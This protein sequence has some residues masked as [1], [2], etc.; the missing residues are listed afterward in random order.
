MATVV[1][2]GACSDRSLASPGAPSGLSV[3]VGS[4]ERVRS[5]VASLTVPEKRDLLSLLDD[6]ERRC[7]DFMPRR[8]ITRAEAERELGRPASSSTRREGTLTVDTV[9]FADGARRITMEFVEGI[10]V[11]YS[12]TP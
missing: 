1:A 4:L 9:V 10:L 6:A 7:A 8:G 2:E 5:S 12:V 3:P 11:R